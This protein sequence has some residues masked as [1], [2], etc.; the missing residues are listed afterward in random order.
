MPLRR[1]M[2]AGLR[3][4]FRSTIGKKMLVKKEE[5]LFVA[6]LLDKINDKQ[7]VSEIMQQIHRVYFNPAKSISFVYTNDY[8]KKI[9]KGMEITLSEK[10]QMEI[11]E[12]IWYELKQSKIEEE[13][14][15]IIRKWN[16]D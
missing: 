2:L 5:S 3:R 13:I 9:A 8:V 10:E 15:E 12:L 1:R 11:L 4:Y 7:L 6:W 14:K 16:Q